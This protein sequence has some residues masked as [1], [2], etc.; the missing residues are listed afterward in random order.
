MACCIRIGFPGCFPEIMS[1]GREKCT[2]D[3]SA[4]CPWKNCL[5][6]SNILPIRAGRNG[7]LCR[8][9]TIWA[10]DAYKKGKRTTLPGA[11][12]HS[13]GGVFKML[14]V[15]RGFMDGW[16][17]VCLSITHFFYT[18]LKYLKLYELQRK[19]KKALS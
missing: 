11:L 15:R 10:E 16:M 14:I 9:T 1:N 17:G 13:V 8:Y 3:R 4:L 19:N 18:L 7:K 2:S 5:G 6:T 12:L